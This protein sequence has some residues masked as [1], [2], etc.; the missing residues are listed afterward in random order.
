[1]GEVLDQV[2]RSLTN[3]RPRNGREYVA[4]QIAK[5]FNDTHR[6][7]RYIVVA[8]DHPRRVMLEAA[9]QATLRHGLNRASAGDLFFE[10]LTE[11]DQGRRP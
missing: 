5:R 7:G 8:R 1:M 3:F 2:D 6:L 4:L 11:F 9:R 10:I